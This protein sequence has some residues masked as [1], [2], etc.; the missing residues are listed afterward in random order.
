MVNPRSERI[1][2]RY[3]IAM[4]TKTRYIGTCA[5]CWQ[6]VRCPNGVLAHHG[7]ERPGW[8]YIHGSCPGTGH[9]P[10]EVNVVTGQMGLDYFTQKVVDLIR[11]LAELPNATQLTTYRRSKPI[12][13]AETPPSTWEIYYEAIEN[14]FRKDIQQATKLRDDYAQKVRDW[15]PTKVTTL[16]EEE[17]VKR[18]KADASRVIRLKRYTENRDKT[19]VYLRRAFD[20]ILK[21]EAIVKASRDAAKT[22]KA[23]AELCKVARV[24]Y[25]SYGSSPY[26]LQTNYPGDVGLDFILADLQLDDMFKHMGLLQNGEYAP[27]RQARTWESTNMYWYEPS[28]FLSGGLDGWVP[29]WP[30][31]TGTVYYPEGSTGKDLDR[32]FWPT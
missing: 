23:L 18:E 19:R 12:I 10:W 5:M 16:E 9:Y 15:Q 6:K 29:F 31:W 3:L 17:T 8:G 2:S 20:K 7:Y 25:A 27:S 11:Q 26:K 24:I 28:D 1:V 13:K 32:R 14:D 22:A 30:G 21:N 4:A